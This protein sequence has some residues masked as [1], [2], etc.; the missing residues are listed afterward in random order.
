MPHKQIKGKNLPSLVHEFLAWKGVTGTDN[1]IRAYRETL[2]CFAYYCYER[3]K[4]PLVP[5]T[6]NEWVAHLRAPE[7]GVRRKGGTINNYIGRVNSFFEWAIQMD[8]VLKNPTK[9]IP[10][11]PQE[12]AHVRGFKEE[13]VK[14]LLISAGAD[15]TRPYWSPMILLGHH[16]GMRIQDCCEFSANCVEWD[17]QCFT[18]MPQ[19]QKAK[20]IELPLHD[21]LAVALKTVS[22]GDTHY[23]PLAVDRYYSNSVGSEFKEIVRR[24]Q[25][26]DNLSFHCLRH[27]AATNMIKAGINLTTIVEII[28]WSSTAMLQRYLD[29]DEGEIAK[30]T[31]NSSVISP[32]PQCS[33]P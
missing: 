31:M 3:G 23:F 7:K 6:I 1:T 13:E 9:L 14:K 27:G 22:P 17:R 21:D 11:L 5:R 29:R 26:S 4:D 32:G 15:D 20:E 33:T 18:F 10:K 12:A 16:Y 28:G 24:A 19:K 8:Y 2:D 25:L 30:L